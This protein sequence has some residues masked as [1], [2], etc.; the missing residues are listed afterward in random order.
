M[1]E[2]GI[3][4]DSPIISEYA[5][6][7]AFWWNGEWRGRPMSC[8]VTDLR[9]FCKVGKKMAAFYVFDTPHGV[10]LRPEIKL[11]DEWIKVAHRGDGGG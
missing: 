4:P 6:R 3:K 7:R 1:A 9:A 2:Y 8:F 5:L 11:I 10:Y